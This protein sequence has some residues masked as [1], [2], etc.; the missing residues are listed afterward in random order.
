MKL[1]NDFYGQTNFAEQKKTIFSSIIFVVHWPHAIQFIRRMAEKNKSETC[2]FGWANNLYFCWT[3]SMSKYRKKNGKKWKEANQLKINKHRRKLIWCSIRW[4]FHAQIDKETCASRSPH[5]HKTHKIKTRNA[6]PHSTFFSSFFPV[7][8]MTTTVRAIWIFFSVFAKHRKCTQ[9]KRKKTWN[10]N[11]NES[12]V[13]YMVESQRLSS[14]ISTPPVV[15]YFNWYN[16]RQSSNACERMRSWQKNCRALH[17]M[18]L[19]RLYV[20]RFLFGC[21]L[22]IFISQSAKIATSLVFFSASVSMSLPSSSPLFLSSSVVHI[23]CVCS[24]LLSENE[25][26]EA[27]EETCAQKKKK[28]F[29][30]WFALAYACPCVWVRTSV[31]LSFLFS[32]LSTHSFSVRRSF[33]TPNSSHMN[34]V[35]R[36]LCMATRH[37]CLCL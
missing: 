13:G 29:F 33:F 10:E 32:S 31:G 20:F 36:I 2:P 17:E 35:E 1:Q 18:K 27:R 3:K 37:V 15:L 25:N 22:L 23:S 9:K 7:T 19:L 4:A 24:R 30:K 5:K 16:T 34:A 21:V 28:N 26:D 8:S 14:H 11:E 12:T 6:M